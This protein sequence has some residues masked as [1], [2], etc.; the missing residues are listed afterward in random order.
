L[1]W[2]T[3][4]FL[5]LFGYYLI[6]RYN[7]K[8]KNKL[9]TILLALSLTSLVGF[10][11]GD[12]IELDA[13]LTART[14]P[15]FLKYTKNIATTL[16]EGTTGEVVE[17][18]KFSTGN[19]GIKMKVA[20]GP[21][22]GQSYW[23][24][25]NK[26][27]PAIKLASRDSKKEVEPEVI[28]VVEKTNAPVE[29][30]QAETKMEVTGR[31][32]IEEHSL[33]EATRAADIA[34]GKEFLGE[35]VSPK[36]LPCVAGGDSPLSQN[37]DTYSPQNAL[38]DINSGELKFVGRE[39]MPGS[40][41]NRTCVYQNAKVY[42]LY[43]NCMAS[44]K[45]AQATDI[46]VISKQG[47]SMKF[48]VEIF[49]AGKPMSK[50]SRDEYKKGT[51]SIVYTKTPAPG[52]LNISKMSDYIKSNEINGDACFIGESFKA[53]DMNTKSSCMGEVEN[54]VS[55]W[56]PSAESFWKNPPQEWYSTQS[57]LR[58]LVET[59]PF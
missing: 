9:P 23:V 44:R 36:I 47:G 18:K 48:Y 19:S 12:E 35:T 31:R 51:F 16:A 6:G 3:P 21:K 52:N 1:N 4:A 39:L 42:V 22:A 40:G 58:K 27:T 30:I 41:Q 38:A 25:Y 15:D 7:D 33:E 2:F 45:E 29:P 59:T 11:T 57:K 14:S 13:F 56:A 17:I 49:D 37:V 24:Y 46:E 20:S 34:L 28:P 53:Q 8:M 5:A 54:K 26:K 10:S 32:D 50:L 43:N 55:D